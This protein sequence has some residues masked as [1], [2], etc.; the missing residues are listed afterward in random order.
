[1]QRTTVALSAVATLISSVSVARAQLPSIPGSTGWPCA[2]GPS[3]TGSSPRLEQTTIAGYPVDVLLPNGYPESE[4]RYP[5]VYVLHGGGQTAHTW[6]EFSEIIELTEDKDVIA[7]FPG[8]DRIGWWSDWRDGSLSVESDVIGKIIPAIDATYRTISDR[9]HRA[10]FGE[11]MGGFGTMHFASR[12]PDLFGFAGS[13]S[14]AVFS[15]E[16]MAVA[17]TA[18]HVGIDAICGDT[19]DP[20]GMFGNFVTE[21]IHWR[22]NDPVDLARNLAGVSLYI[23]F[24]NGIPCDP[25]RDLPRL[26]EIYPVGELAAPAGEDFVRALEREQIPHTVDRLSCGMHDW[27][28]FSEQ[29]RHLWPQLEGVFANGDSTAPASFDFKRAAPEFSIWG[30]TF[31][32]DARRA[33]EFLDV[34]EASCAGLKLTGSGTA[35]ITTAPCFSPGRS[36]VVEGS[37]ENDVIA[38]GAGSITFTVDLGPPHSMQ[39]YT[40][41]QKLLEASGDYFTSRTVTFQAD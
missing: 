27:P 19:R 18:L 35:S 38:D 12:H 22:D 4:R 9:A 30:W 14:G 8:S 25:A 34:A 26:V 17:F 3:Y 39:Q 24:G 41:P 28:Y 31:S 32:A 13:V 6:P 37:V 11:S 7:V 36:V 21:E 15:E 23:G 40:L 1:M 33:A 20:N 29:M 2:P 10:V 16:T 5:V